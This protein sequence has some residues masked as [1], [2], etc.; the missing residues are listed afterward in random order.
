VRESHR[1]VQSQSDH[2]LSLL[3]KIP[4]DFMQNVGVKKQADEK[5]DFVCSLS[6]SKQDNYNLEDLGIQTNLYTLVLVTF[7]SICVL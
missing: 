4:T 2:L 1:L 7:Y 3:R 5:S 6:H